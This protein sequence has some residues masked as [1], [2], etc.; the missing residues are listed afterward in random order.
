M[1]GCFGFFVAAYGLLS[2]CGLLNCGGLSCC[3]A[4]ALGWLGFSSCG[5]WA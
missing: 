2:S 4:G 3:G 5:V 1:F